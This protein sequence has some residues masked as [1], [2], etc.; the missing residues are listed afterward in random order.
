MSALSFLV[1]A[2][3][4]TGFG[5]AHAASY[6]LA[7]SFSILSLVSRP[8]IVAVPLVPS[9]SC[10]LVLPGHYRV[11]STLRFSCC[12]IGTHVSRH[13]DELE[14]LSVSA[15]HSIECDDHSSRE[16][17]HRRSR[18]DDKNRPGNLI[19]SI[20]AIIS[21]SCTFGHVDKYRR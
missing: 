16:S 21:V 12:V 20:R 2:A 15:V 7:I 10:L 13:N 11:I 17:C 9:P 4:V 14:F 18:R 5:H 6:S 8:Y 19:L 1:C 3:V